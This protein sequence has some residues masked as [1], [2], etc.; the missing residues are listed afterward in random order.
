MPCR[1]VMRLGVSSKH[2]FL[3]FSSNAVHHTDPLLSV[4]VSHVISFWCHNEPWLF[5]SIC[6]NRSFDFSMDDNARDC[7][8]HYA[9]S[10]HGRFRFGVA[11]C[12]HSYSYSICYYYCLNCPFPSCIT[13][14]PYVNMW[15]GNRDIVTVFRGFSFRNYCSLWNQSE[16]LSDCERNHWLDKI[17]FFFFS[18]GIHP[19]G[20]VR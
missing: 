13:G 9:L 7:H 10:R 16:H 19:A 12:C 1:S 3:F 2:S 6:S 14:F 18:Q 11:V 15:T 4:I 20:G 5:N 8:P 17:I